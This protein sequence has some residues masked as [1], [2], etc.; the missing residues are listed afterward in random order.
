MENSLWKRLRTCR[1][2]DCRMNEYC[3]YFQSTLTPKPIFKSGQIVKPVEHLVESCIIC[4]LFV[5]CT[6]CYFHTFVCNKFFRVRN[7]TNNTNAWRASMQ[8]Y[9]CDLLFNWAPQ[10]NMRL[11]GFRESQCDWSSDRPGSTYLTHHPLRGPAAKVK[12]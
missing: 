12:A 7:A 5:C 4:K 6:N 8:R 2:S 11:S 9:A 1:K 10:L 3:V